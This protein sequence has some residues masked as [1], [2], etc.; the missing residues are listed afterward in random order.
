MNKYERCQTYT[1]EKNVKCVGLTPLLF[2]KNLDLII[3]SK[4]P[5]IYHLGRGMYWGNAVAEHIK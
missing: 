1:F 2:S 3:T 4:F 5:I